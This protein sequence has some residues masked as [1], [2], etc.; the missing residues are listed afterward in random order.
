M[1]KLPISVL[2]EKWTNENKGP[3]IVFGYPKCCID[4]FC[5][6]PPELM[7]GKPSKNDI[8]RWEASK[9]FGKETG[10]I[11]CSAHAKQIKQGKIQLHQLIKGR[12]TLHPFPAP[13]LVAC[14]NESVTIISEVVGEENFKVN[15]L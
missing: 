15:E 8:R 2:I 11:P 4:E 12:K 1:K 10:F 7:T 14:D 5:R 9:M 3:G 13:C 6:Q